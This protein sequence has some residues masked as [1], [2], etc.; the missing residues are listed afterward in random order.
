MKFSLARDFLQKLPKIVFIDWLIRRLTLGPV[1][2][3][4]KAG[5]KS[6]PPVLLNVELILAM[7]ALSLKTKV[8]SKLRPR[9]FKNG[10]AVKLI[11]L[12]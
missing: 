11:S 1:V 7:L 12:C 3:L 6:T 9:K 5:M 4:M 10:E 8:N 2:D